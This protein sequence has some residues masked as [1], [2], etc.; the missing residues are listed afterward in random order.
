MKRILL[1]SPPTPFS[2]FPNSGPHIGLGYLLSFLQLHGFTADYLNLEAADPEKVVIPE[3][4]DF[5]GMTAVTAQY[6][7]ANKIRKQIAA[8]KLGKTIIGGVH[9]SVLPQDC[10]KDG[11]DY[12][13]IGYGEKALLKIAGGSAKPGIVDGMAIE[14]LNCLP[15]PAWEK[16]FKPFDVSY[17]RKTGHILTM[18]GCPFRCYYCCSEKVYGPRPFF[19]SVEN[20]RQEVE[21]LIGQ[22]GIT[23]LYFYDATFSFLRERAMKIAEMLKTFG[24]HWSFQTRVD[25][26]DPE[27]LEKL[28]EGGCDQISLGIETGSS[29]VETLGKKTTESQ[30]A[31]AINWCHDAGIR[32]KAYLIGAL[33]DDTKRSNE[34]FK[35]FLLKYGPDDWLYSTFMAFPGTPYWDQPE[36][37]GLNIHTRDYRLLY[38]LGL[39]ARG[40]VNMST[41]SMSRDALYESREDMLKFLRKNFPNPRV[42]RAMELFP[43]QRPLFNQ[44]LG[45][46]VF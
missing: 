9:A 27:L 19:R 36:R 23:H 12:I 22:F 2:A 21:G 30:N 41:A 46:Y 20:I 14:N 31:Q 39:N 32:V 5:Y 3:G 42:E 15:F 38:P 29:V 43:V 11:F 33:P 37:F 6:H 13:V 35:E 40:P 18:R 26:V 10:L 7:Y 44:S 17:G 1:I 28:R 25:L 24:I 45:D 16:V 8:R 4:Y 34:D